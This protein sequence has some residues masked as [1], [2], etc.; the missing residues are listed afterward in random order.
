M[1]TKICVFQ[2]NPISF[3]LGKDKSVMINATEMAKVFNKLVKDFMSN[4]GTKKFIEECLKKDNSPFL[5]INSEEDLYV[6]RQKSGT[7]MHRILALKFAAWLSPAFELW[8][9]S[10]IDSLLFGKYV[11]REKSF[12]RTLLLQKERDELKYKTE[13]TGEDFDLYLT[14]ESELNKEKAVRK[15]LTIESV[16]GMKNIFD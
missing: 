15:S 5:N 10:T 8:I 11:E 4:D 13:K 6:S 12:E 9:Y 2:E 14:I 7:W 1:E 16:S 3:N